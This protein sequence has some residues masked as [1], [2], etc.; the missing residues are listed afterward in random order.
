MIKSITFTRHIRDTTRYERLSSFFAALGFEIGNGPDNFE[1]EDRRFLAPVG[2]LD[3]VHAAEPARD[4]SLLE[5]N[6]ESNEVRIEVTCLDSIHQAAKVW[7]DGQDEGV[8]ATLGEIID[9]PWDSRL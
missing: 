7:L 8:P 4:R 5:G 2:G 3:L 6:E 1:R 9:T